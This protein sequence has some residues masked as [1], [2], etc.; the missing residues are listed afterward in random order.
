MQKVVYVKDTFE[1]YLGKPDISASDLK[2]F[3]QSPAYYKYKS[4]EVKKDEQG[5]HFLIGSA[6]HELLLEPEFFNQTY[7]VMPKFDLRT[8]AGKE[9]HQSFTE[10]HKG[11]VFLDKDDYEMIIAMSKSAERSNTFMDLISDSYRELSCYTVDENSGLGVRMRP[12]CF[13]KNRSTIVDIKT[14]L[15]SSYKGFKGDVY[16]FGYSITAAFY[17]DFLNR[18]NY[19]FAAIEKQP[20]YQTALY[21]LDDEMIEYGRK[22]YRMGLDLLKWSRDNDFYC[23][24]N[25]FE[26]LKECYEIGNLD[27]FHDILDKSE[28]ITIIH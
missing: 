12:D 25:E 7:L 4:T 19:V 20:P 14:C 24:Y 9:E 28:K 6:F 5:K 8:K 22:Q 26:I 21:M 17:M 27:D 15:N 10:N 13:A 3:L 11:K 23:S 18:E 1:E 2:N 16:K